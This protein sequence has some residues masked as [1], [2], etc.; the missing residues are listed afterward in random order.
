VS[1]NYGHSDS[2]RDVSSTMAAA[3]PQ[4]AAGIP[5]QLGVVDLVWQ[6]SKPERM[7]FQGVVSI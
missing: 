6:K 7:L 2:W 1:D 4:E 3:L 5:G